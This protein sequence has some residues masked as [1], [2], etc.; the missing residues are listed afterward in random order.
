MKTFNLPFGI[1]VETSTDGGSIQSRLYKDKHTT[2]KQSDI[3]ESMILAHACAGVD[4]SDYKY[5]D[6]LY[7]CLEAM[8]NNS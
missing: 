4:V 2:R 3:V 6:G 7:N 5:I 8:A 1:I